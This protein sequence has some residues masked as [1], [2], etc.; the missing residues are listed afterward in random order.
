ML[1]TVPNRCYLGV[2]YLSRAEIASALPHIDEACS[3]EAYL[4][5]SLGAGVVDGVSLERQAQKE[6]LAT[7]KSPVAVVESKSP[8]VQREDVENAVFPSPPVVP[9]DYP[10]LHDLNVI[11]FGFEHIHLEGIDCGPRGSNE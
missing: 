8:S 6:A 9:D 11:I 4:S 7:V 10:L 5:A 1:Y 3:C 2:L